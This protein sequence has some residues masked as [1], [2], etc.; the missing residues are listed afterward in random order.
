MRY[1]DKTFFKFLFGLGLIIVFGLV[2]ISK[3]QAQTG[4]ININTASSAELQTL[5]GIGPTYAQRIIDYRNQ[6]GPFKTID[7]IKNV[8]GIGDSTFEKIKNDIT[9]G[10]TNQTANTTQNSASALNINNPETSSSSSGEVES[11]EIDVYGEDVGVVG[12]PIEFRAEANSKKATLIWVF[13]DGGVAYGRV[14]THSYKY[15]GEYVVVLNASMSGNKVVSRINIKIV[16]DTLV[17]SQASY[18]KIEITN[19]GKEEISLHGR[20]I[21]VGDKYF[22]FPE[23]TIIKAGQKISFPDFITG[24]S[25]SDRSQ[26]LLSVSNLN[27]GV[28]VDENLKSKDNQDQIEDITRQIISLQKKQLEIRESNK[29]D[30]SKQLALAISAQESLATTSSEKNKKTNGWV[31]TIKRFFGFK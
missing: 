22:V 23:G 9:V 11:L 15:P 5:N 12:Q 30:P 29:V 14:V 3:V 6:N 20:E 8:S 7:E 17:V 24:L 31:S 1:F 28:R 4:L 21:R 16:P 27:Q 19:S 18:E 10:T 13:G 25:P 2:F 26:V